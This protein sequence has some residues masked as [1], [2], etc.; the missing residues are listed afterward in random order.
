MRTIQP[1][2]RD[3]VNSASYPALKTPG[4]Y[5]GVPPGQ[6]LSIGVHRNSFT[7]GK[8]SPK[9]KLFIIKNCSFNKLPFN[10][11]IP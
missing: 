4:Y 1:S 2:L 3:F 8:L 7:S 9:C 6:W 5:R 10:E 11:D